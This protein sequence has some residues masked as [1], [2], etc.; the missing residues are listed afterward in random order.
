MILRASVLHTVPATFLF[1]F[2][3]L[4]WTFFT[5]MRFIYEIILLQFV[6]CCSNFHGWLV[7]NTSKTKKKKQSKKKNKQEW[8]E[9][10][11]FSIF[12]V[13]VEFVRSREYRGFFNGKIHVACINKGLSESSLRE[14]L[15]E[16]YADSGLDKW[17]QLKINAD[18][19]HSLE[20]RIPLV[21]RIPNFSIFHICARCQ[22]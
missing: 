2:F 20:S 9:K 8:N 5:L 15:Y 12:R 11:V 17:S 6:F 3:L 1:H 7:Q 14:K 18:P 4:N 13:V 19:R 16:S 10:N 21:A 22:F